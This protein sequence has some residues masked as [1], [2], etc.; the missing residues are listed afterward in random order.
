[1]PPKHRP[2]APVDL[3]QFGGGE[4]DE[5]A[6]EKPAIVEGADLIEEDLGVALQSFSGGKA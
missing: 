5:G 6:F 4:M 1:M 2:E 3:F